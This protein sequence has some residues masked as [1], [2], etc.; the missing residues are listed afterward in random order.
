[1]FTTPAYKEISAVIFSS[2]ASIGKVRALS[3]DPSPDIYFKAFRLNPGS[4]LPHFINQP[5]QRYEE[6]LLDGL[7]IYHNPF[8]T[9]PLDPAVFRHP[10]VFQSYYHKDDWVYEQR[11]GLLLTRFVFSL[12]LRD[13]KPLE[14]L[15]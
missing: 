5:K 14:R 9:H 3:S 4:D 10:S 13:R 12:S 8:A 1:M 6:N 15:Y 11:D 7:R 2:C